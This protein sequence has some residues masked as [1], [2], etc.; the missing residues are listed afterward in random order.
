MCFV[1]QVKWHLCLTD[2]AQNLNK[3]KLSNIRMEYKTFLSWNK[4]FLKYGGHNICNFE[5]FCWQHCWSDL[6]EILLKSVQS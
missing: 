6:L 1:L 3:S 2:V 5:L 4:P